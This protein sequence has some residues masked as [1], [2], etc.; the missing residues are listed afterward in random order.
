MTT[1][2][3]PFDAPENQEVEWQDLSYAPTRYLGPEAGQNGAWS[4]LRNTNGD[5]I[6]VA[7]SDY[8]QAA[9]ISWVQ[10][11]DEVT[12]VSDFFSQMK[13]AGIPAGA[14]YDAAVRLPGITFDE[15]QYGDLENVVTLV[16]QLSA[17]PPALLFEQ[18]PPPDGD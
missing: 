8:D 9:G 16:A 5:V 18:P 10:Q 6:A 2:N 13:A 15:E 17:Q 12:Q 14:A 4:T 1:Y 11:P 3:I 7:Y